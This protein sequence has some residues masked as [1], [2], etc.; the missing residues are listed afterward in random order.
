MNDALF[1]QLGKLAADASEQV[2]F[3]GGFG[4]R[5]EDVEGYVRID[6]FLDYYDTVAAFVSAVKKRL[7]GVDPAIL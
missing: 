4:E 1:M 2:E 3:R 6:D 7:R 5:S